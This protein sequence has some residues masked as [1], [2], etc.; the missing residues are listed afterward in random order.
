MPKMGKKKGKVSKA[1]KAFVHKAIDLTTEDKYIYGPITAV[2]LNNTTQISS[3]HLV[4]PAHGNTSADRIGQ[5]IKIKYIRLSLEG[6][7]S[8]ATTVSAVA[9]KFQ[10]FRMAMIRMN[11]TNAAALVTAGTNQGI[12]QTTVAGCGYSTALYNPITVNSKLSSD[13]NKLYSICYDQARL[14]KPI[15]SGQDLSSADTIGDICKW[16]ITKKYPKGLYVNFTAATTGANTSVTDYTH[17]LVGSVGDTLVDDS[18]SFS[19]DGHYEICY[20]DA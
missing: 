7:Y 10:T 8:S 13:H 5:R 14:I 12:F 6:R 18:A 15:Y 4:L 20:E 17:W 2:T 1:V 16:R 9:Q 11:Q 19:Y 3:Q